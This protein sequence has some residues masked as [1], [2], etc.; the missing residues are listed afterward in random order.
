MPVRALRVVLHW[1]PA[2]G[3]YSV[4]FPLIVATAAAAV[5]GASLS[6]TGPLAYLVVA[7][8][9]V[10]PRIRPR[11]SGW[12]GQARPTWALAVASISKPCIRAWPEDDCA[13]SSLAKA[14]STEL[15]NKKLLAAFVA[16]KVLGNGSCTIADGGYCRA[17]RLP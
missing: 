10:R 16:A 11:L 12:R 7:I 13:W 5:L 8:Y 17:T 15:P 3:T 6:W 1:T 9:A 14:Y 4:M 2:D